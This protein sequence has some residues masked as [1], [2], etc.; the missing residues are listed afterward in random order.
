MHQAS[1]PPAIGTPAKNRPG[2]WVQTERKAHEA[3]A[4]L[5]ARKEVSAAEVLEA[6]EQGWSS[7]A[8]LAFFARNPAPAGSI[9]RDWRGLDPR[10]DEPDDDS[11]E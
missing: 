4:G 3:W 5:I 10:R 9:E 1:G 8:E 2:Q 11:D 6:G 7:A